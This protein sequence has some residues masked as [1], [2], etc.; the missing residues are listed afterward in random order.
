[1][2]DNKGFNYPPNTEMENDS[3][4]TEILQLLKEAVLPETEQLFPEFIADD[5][6]SDE[7]SL[8]L[9]PEL[10]EETLLDE[11]WAKL[12]AEYNTNPTAFLANF[13]EDIENLPEL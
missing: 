5:G 4:L 9:E 7:G 1:M 12:R 2:S 10:E 13:E 8:F 3:S 11:T 6:V